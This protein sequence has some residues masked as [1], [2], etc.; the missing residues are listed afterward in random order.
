MSW[1]ALAVALGAIGCTTLPPGR[2]SVDDITILG[3]HHLDE[4]DIEEKLATTESPMFLG[5][6]R[7]V[8]YEYEVYDRYVLQYDLARIERL[9]K[10]RGFYDAHARAGRVFPS[11]D[12]KHVRIEIVVE[13]GEPVH[14]AQSQ[15]IL[16][17]DLSY[18]D[19]LRMRAAAEKALSKDAILDETA[20][21]ASEHAAQRA[22]AD[23][24]YA[25]A[26]VAVR[27][28]VDLPK[29]K[30]NLY[31]SV[32]PHEK[33]V[34]GVIT[35][36]GLGNLPDPPI[37]RALDLTPGSP[38]SLSEL[39]SARQAVLELG[40]T[41]L[42]V[43][44]TPFNDATP[45]VVPILVKVEAARLRA[46]KLG[47]GFELDALKTDIHVS[48]R[49][50]DR[51]FLGGLRH[52]SIGLTPGL[53]LY[54]TRLGYFQAPETVLP[55]VKLRLELRR[56]GFLEART[57][58]F[59][60]PELNVAPVLV[61]PE[62]NPVDP[63]LGYAEVKTTTGLQRR[64]GSRLDVTLSHSLQVEYPFLY[65]GAFDP[66]SSQP[67]PQTIVIS[68]P[69]LYTTLDLR[70][71]PIHPRLGAFFGNDIQ[72]AGLGGAPRDIRVQPEAR[73]YL[74]LGRRVTIAARASL[75]F[76]IPFNY[77]SGTDTR[78]AQIVYFRGFFSGGPTTN[79]G[80]PPR[81]ISPQGVVAFYNP[82]VDAQQANKVCTSF[83]TRPECVVPL[84]GLSL[85]ESSLEVR[86]H[87]VGPLSTAV[88][89]DL[90]DVSPLTFDLRFNRP[91]LSCGGGAR[92][93]TPVGPIRIDIGYRIPGAQVF[94]GPTEYVPELIRGVPVALQLGL[95]EAY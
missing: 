40:V 51:N 48:A 27:V 81:G 12:T 88:F 11:R 92:Y 55:E 73:G 39:D 13:E 66:A 21:D 30:A 89:C 46:V 93:D 43:I 64:F 28:E 62:Y 57:T 76:L 32:E 38:Y 68:Y 94:A 34:Y 58:G 17:G 59:F 79:R 60:R 69:E 29:H 84:G 67:P 2:S 14:V 45:G 33:Y 87:L 56:S 20:L 9:Y 25:K 24:G 44:E 15:F 7:G 95:G 53:V 71:D 35:I 65:R 22:L 31:Y 83:D 1:L 90:G 47:G 85:W 19:V 72:F 91:H 3:A 8:V 77:Q 37:R 18:E 86:I 49:W 4:E 74:P 61:R 70:D 52:V 26:T 63:V 80:Y 41:S 16:N 82:A 78:D 6:F 75:G 23:R 36:L 5:V 42:V 50:E 54:P 10:A